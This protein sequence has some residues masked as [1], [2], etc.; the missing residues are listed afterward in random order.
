M[1]M[2]LDNSILDISAQPMGGHIVLVVRGELDVYN[3]ARFREQ[4]VEQ[5]TAGRHTLV[6]DMSAVSFLDSSALGVLV[7]AFKRARAHSGCVCLLNPSNRLRR[8]LA[9]T[10]LNKIFR[11]FDD[12]Q[13]A[14]D[15]LD[16]LGAR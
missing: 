15:H 9:I 1:T 10:G 16:G 6:L 14:L 11:V 13:A 5:S 12:L 8:T 7:G 3:H 2:N 4:L